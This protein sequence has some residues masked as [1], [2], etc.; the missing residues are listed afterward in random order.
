MEAIV[1]NP[2][3][4][5]DA[6]QIQDIPRPAPRPD[7]LLVRVRASSVCRGDVNLRRIPKLILAPMGLLFGFKPTKI[8]GVEFA[9]IIEAVGASVIRFKPGDEVFGTATGLAYGGNAEYLCVPE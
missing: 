7:E 4:D 9:G 1:I 8:P 3:K 5:A 6:L 2:G